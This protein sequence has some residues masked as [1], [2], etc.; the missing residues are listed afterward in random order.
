MNFKRDRFYSERFI[1]NNHWLVSV[2][3]KQLFQELDAIGLE[4]W[5]QA[6]TFGD[7]LDS[8]NDEQYDYLKSLR[9]KEWMSD[10]DERSF[11]IDLGES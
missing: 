3:K 7:F 11:G 5:A 8:L 4:M 10:I 6:E 9:I 1:M 2:K